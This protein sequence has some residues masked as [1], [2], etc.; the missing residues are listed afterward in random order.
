MQ[1]KMTVIAAA[2]GLLALG[3]CGVYQDYPNDENAVRHNNGAHH[4]MHM[5]DGHEHHVHGDYGHTHANHHISHQHN[6]DHDHFEGEAAVG[7]DEESYMEDNDDKWM[8]NSC[9]P[10][11]AKRGD[12]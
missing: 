7:Q 5:H 12:C 6:G 10:G 3:A 11:A 4:E 8:Y 9:P 1:L 2:G